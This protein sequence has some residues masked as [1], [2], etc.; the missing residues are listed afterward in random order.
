MPRLL[1]S[2]FNNSISL[3]S[4]FQPLSFSIEIDLKC[5]L[6][7]DDE[8]QQSTAL[9]WIAEFLDFAQD[10]MV[11]FTPRLIPAILPNLAHH[12]GAIQSAALQTN[13]SLFTVIEALPSPQPSQPP[14]PPPQQVQPNPTGSSTS[15]VRPV[16][17]S[18]PA[19]D[20]QTLPF[21]R[22]SNPQQDAKT[23]DSSAQAPSRSQL[24][25]ARGNRDRD[26]TIGPPPTTESNTD[27]LP[28]SRSQSP[29][30]LGLRSGAGAA[31]NPLSATSSTTS[32]RSETANATSTV[33]NIASAWQQSQAQS[34]SQ[35]VLQMQSQVHD[36]QAANPDTPSFTTSPVEDPEADPF[37]YQA[38]VSGLMVQFLSEYVETRVAALK[39]LLMLHQKAPKK[40][41][42]Q[43]VCFDPHLK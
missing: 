13:R 2:F 21:P 33:T 37:D 40:V 22:N 5:L 27:Q 35:A 23:V 17:S 30:F 24:P 8:I 18:P 42:S 31:P 10:V 20:T 11:P 6:V 1:K 34:Q 4:I 36:G 14:P 16:P 38:T 7:S 9:R 19:P 41:R 32:Q 3:V 28:P 29:T 39:W 15:S 26:R 12:V 25:V 43:I